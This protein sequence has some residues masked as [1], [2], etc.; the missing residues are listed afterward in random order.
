LEVAN[1]RNFKRFHARH[2]DTRT[3]V[4]PRMPIALFC[5]LVVGAALCV[6][7]YGLDLNAGFFNAPS[8]RARIMAIS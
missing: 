7:T 4:H 1:E 8:R 3:D 5:A 6:A 2:P